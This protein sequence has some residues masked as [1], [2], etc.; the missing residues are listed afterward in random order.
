MKP[1]VS[2]AK[3]MIKVYDWSISQLSDVA[4]HGPPTMHVHCWQLYAGETREEALRTDLE[5]RQYWIDIFNKGV[6]TND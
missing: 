3:T 6:N 1:T 2:N 4:L 5:R